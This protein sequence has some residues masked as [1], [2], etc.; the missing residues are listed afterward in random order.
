MVS[1]EKRRSLKRLVVTR[2]A[3]PYGNLNILAEFIAAQLKIRVLFRKAIKKAIELTELIQK[4][5]KFKYKRNLN[6]KVKIKILIFYH[7]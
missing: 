3:K 2:I 7:E 6:T 1:Q 5:F 4:E